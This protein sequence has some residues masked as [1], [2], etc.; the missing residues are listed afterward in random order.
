MQDPKVIA[1][2][3]QMTTETIEQAY[4]HPFILGWSVC[5]E[6]ETNKPGGRR[7]FEIRY[8]LV[9]KLDPDRYVSYADSH[10]SEGADPK[11]F[12]T[13]SGP[14][15]NLIPALER[16]KNDYPYKMFIIS[17]FGA[18]GMFAP[19]KKT[20][21]ELRVSIIRRQMDVFRKY[22]FIAGAGG[23][24]MERRRSREAHGLPCD[25]RAPG[26]EFDFF[27]HVARVFLLVGIA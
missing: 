21:D 14:R 8:N 22:D 16:A 18:A 3:K 26:R 11:D 15:D 6:T 9:K 2:A 27:L 13:W 23:A 17:E 12:G 19:D 4:N 25:G 20:G 7:Y 24:S 10:I 5:N 1:L